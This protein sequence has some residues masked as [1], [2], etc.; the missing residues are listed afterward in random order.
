MTGRTVPLAGL[1]GIL[2]V[3]LL[4]GLKGALV[5]LEKARGRARVYRKW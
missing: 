5:L 1:A 2:S 3:V 4:A